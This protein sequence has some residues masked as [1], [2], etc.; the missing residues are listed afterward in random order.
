[1]NPMWA[2]CAE[3]QL[4][5]SG[6]ILLLFAAVIIRGYVALYSV[7]LTEDVRWLIRAFLRNPLLLDHYWDLV[8]GPSL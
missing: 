1:M 7:G 6:A 8:D 3:V 5:G 2:V 4:L